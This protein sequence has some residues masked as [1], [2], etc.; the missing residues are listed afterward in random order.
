[1]YGTADIQK[2]YTLVNHKSSEE[3]NS[4]AMSETYNVK[5]SSKI[6]RAYCERFKA[7]KDF[8]YFNKY[9]INGSQPYRY[10]EL[11]FTMNRITEKT[12]V[13]TI[14]F[15]LLSILGALIAKVADSA[16]MN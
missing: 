8:S 15:C 9:I 1:M 12:M 2:K 11:L 7:L 4:T 10:D 13:Q 5:I 14:N 16:F 6:I 3:E